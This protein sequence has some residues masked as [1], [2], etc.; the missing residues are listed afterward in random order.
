MRSIQCLHYQPVFQKKAASLLKMASLLWYL[1]EDLNLLVLFDR[2]IGLT[3]KC[4]MVKVSENVEED[5]PLS[6]TQVDTTNR[7]TNTC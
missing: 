7:K 5:K 4:V 2:N 6:Q 1:T 3:T